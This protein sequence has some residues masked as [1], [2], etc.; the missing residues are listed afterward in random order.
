METKHLMQI[1]DG[2]FA[3]HDLV[4]E[5]EDN[6]SSVGLIQTLPVVGAIDGS[7]LKFNNILECQKH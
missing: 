4:F 2:N 6:L 7:D 3:K 5:W 1:K